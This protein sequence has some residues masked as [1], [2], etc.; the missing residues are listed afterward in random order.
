MEL[1]ALSLVYPC[2]RK[3]II[4]VI[5]LIVYRYPTDEQMTCMHANCHRSQGSYIAI[6]TA[7]HMQ[8]HACCET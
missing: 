7:A 2:S 5:V 4:G 1:V 8:F 3:M 6:Y